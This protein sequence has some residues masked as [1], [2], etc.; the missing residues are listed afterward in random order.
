MG[1]GKFIEGTKLI[2]KCFINIDL[3]SC[4]GY[5]KRQK[6]AVIQQT[7][8]IANSKNKT[9]FP[10]FLNNR[11]HTLSVSASTLA[12]KLLAEHRYQTEN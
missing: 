1:R 9:G 11:L 12:I 6:D 8:Y 5:L 3:N 7:E 2:K 4:S 10:V